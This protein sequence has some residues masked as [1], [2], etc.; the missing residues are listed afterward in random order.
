[1]D[2]L[3]EGFFFA[4]WETGRSIRLSASFCGRKA[5]KEWLRRACKS[6][7]CAMSFKILESSE[8][9]TKALG[10]ALRTT[11]LPRLERARGQ[12]HGGNAEDIRRLLRYRS[13]SSV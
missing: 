3:K 11:S 13:A 6:R 1:M 10:N 5:T 7:E 12:Q 2:Q 9:R 8:Y 4:N